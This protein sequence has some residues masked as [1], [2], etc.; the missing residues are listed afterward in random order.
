MARQKK[1]LNEMSF[2]DHLEE[3]RWLLVRCSAGILIGGVVAYYFSDFIIDTIILGPKKGDFITY[4][5][6]CDL[7][8]GFKNKGILSSCPNKN[9]NLENNSAVSFFSASNEIILSSNNAK[10]S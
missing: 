2:L 6:F 3:L 8:K 9:S 10:P 7:G 4:Q 1:N 5:F